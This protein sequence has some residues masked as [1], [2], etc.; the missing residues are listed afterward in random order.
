MD[1]RPSP[2]A[3]PGPATVATP[4]TSL[5]RIVL[6]RTV[7]G[8]VLMALILIP[9][10]VLMAATKQPSASYAAMGTIIGAVA[11]A[12]GGLRIGVLTSLVVALLAPLS[13]VAGL[14]PLTGAALMALMTLFVGRMSR[15]GLHRAVMLVP[16]FLTWLILS[17]VPWVSRS[18]L[19]AVDNLL[20]TKHLSVAQALATLHPPAGS[21]S[22]SAPATTL[23]NAM[24]E[25]RMDQTYLAWVAA[26]FLVGALVAVAVLP[27]L[28]RRATRPTPATHSRGESMAYTITI[29]VLTTVATFYFLDHPTEL[30]G[31]FLIAAILVLAQVGDEIA[32]KLTV[33]RVLG[34]VGGVLLLTGLL[35]WMGSE[36]FTEVFGI[37]FPARLYL[38]GA[39]CGVLAIIAKFSP[40]QWIYYVL[41]TPTAALLNAYTTSQAA[42]LGTARLV[43]NLVGAVLVILAALITLGASH[44]AR[45]HRAG[46][47]APISIPNV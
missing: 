44:L 9:V 38:V 47:D 5:G 19:G 14:T 25:L 8:V 34:T 11:V 41:I 23:Q 24:V 17:P 6:R 31:S 30:G 29:T 7:M 4:P 35:D 18:D 46:A 2:P 21:T 32:W 39:L 28:L 10:F 13:I 42:H 36:S 16:I 1:H 45:R 22:T 27:L 12:A 33:Q 20:V 37:P 40:R 26:F 15:F 43:D 3:D